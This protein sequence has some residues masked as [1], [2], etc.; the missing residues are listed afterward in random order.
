M[1][2]RLPV[3]GYFDAKSCHIDE[4]R[5]LVSRSLEAS[6]LVFT[7]TVVKNVPI[8]DVAGLGKE[9]EGAGLRRRLMAEWAH[10]L[11]DLSGVLV[12]KGAFADTAPLDEAAKVFHDIIAREKLENGGGADHFAKAGANDRIWNSLQKLCLQAPAVFAGCFGN[13]AIDT[14]C[15]AWLGPNYQMTAQVNLV[16]P[17][18]EAQQAHRDYHLGFQTADISASYPAHVHDLSPVMTLQGGVAHVDMPIESG[19]TKLLPF[20]QLYRAGYAAWRLDEFRA[21]FEKRYIQLPLEKGDALFFNPALFHAAGANRSADVQRLVNLLQ[22]SSAFGRAMESIDR[23]AMCKALY[24][25]LKDAHASGSMSWSSIEAAVSSCAEGYSFPTNLD[26]DPPIGGLAPQTQ[27]QL[28]L[29]AL[30][31]RWDRS[32]FEAAL[33]EQDARRRP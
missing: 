19:P 27:K 1:D 30:S 3:S 5:A 9:L 8:Y 7:D 24:P 17:G 28:F 13:R 10:V 15:E 6:E 25:A 11:K 12:L 33:D 18:G 21:C 2:A 4:F 16:R 31:E 32:S 23:M 26:R 14:V 29:K 22:V 20:S